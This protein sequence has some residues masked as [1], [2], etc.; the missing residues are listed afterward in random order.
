M[1]TRPKTLVSNS[2]RIS[3]EIE[4]ANLRAVGV[5]R[6]VDEHVDAAHAILAGLQGPCVVV[7][8]ADIRAHPMRARPPAT[9]FTRASSRPVK[10]T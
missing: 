4:A 10:T 5:A 3:L 1:S 7:G 2:R 6:V 9:S 8:A